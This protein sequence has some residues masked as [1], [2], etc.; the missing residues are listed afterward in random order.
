MGTEWERT[1]TYLE[2][3]ELE[4]KRERAGVWIRLMSG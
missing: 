1:V 4:E 2:Q 3:E